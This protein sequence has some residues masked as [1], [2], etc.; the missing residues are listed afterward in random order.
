MRLPSPP[1]H[2]HPNSLTVHVYRD[3]ACSGAGTEGEPPRKKRR[4]KWDIAAPDATPTS[5]SAPPT[6][7][8]TPSGAAMAAAAKLNAMLAAQGKLVKSAPAPLLVSIFIQCCVSGAPSLLR[9]NIR[10]NMGAG[11]DYGHVV[12]GPTSLW[13]CLLPN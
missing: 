7:S 5:Q 9:E 11:L 2:L 3:V 10:E 1:C 6:T 13:V 12:H 8:T 4:S